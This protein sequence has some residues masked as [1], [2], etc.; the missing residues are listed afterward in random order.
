MR[1]QWRRRQ[2]LADRLRPF[3]A[4][5]DPEEPMVDA[6]PIR[7]FLFRWMIE[8][9]DPFEVVATGFDLDEG[10][11]ERVVTGQVRRLAP[12]TARQLRLRLGINSLRAAEATRSDQLASA[13]LR[14]PGQPDPR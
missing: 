13:R 12:E 3:V 6:D 14:P 9:G 1:L 2:G 7:M 10:L 8:T 5:A 11:V 4:T